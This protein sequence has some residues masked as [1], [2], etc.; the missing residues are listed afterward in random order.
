MQSPSSA[1]TDRFVIRG[2]RR[3]GFDRMV[4]AGVLDR[5]SVLMLE[6]ELSVIMRTP[7]ALILDLRGL[8]SIDRWGVHALD[9]ATHHADRCGSRLFIVSQG[10][11][12]LA[13]Q[14]AGIRHLLSSA[15]MSDLLES[16]GGAWTPV[17]LPPLPEQRIGEPFR[18]A[19]DAP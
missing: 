9:G 4:L 12:L 6:S 11:V 10:L 8:R 13:L 17:S 5:S 16:D 3:N 7:V 14:A 19:G 2:D 18:V 15:D 1:G